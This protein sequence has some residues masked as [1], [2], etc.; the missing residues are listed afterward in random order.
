MI[1]NKIQIFQKLCAIIRKKIPF[2][3]LS[4]SATAYSAS[5][6]A[7]QVS[8]LLRTYGRYGQFLNIARAHLFIKSALQMT[9]SH[10]IQ[11][12]YDYR[13]TIA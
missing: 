12:N 13:N 8:A 11:L 7:E 6:T 9:V 10:Y 1:Y 2:R 4:F 3:C 5:E